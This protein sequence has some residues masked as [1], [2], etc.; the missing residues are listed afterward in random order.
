MDVTIWKRDS[1]K[2]SR[3]YDAITYYSLRR[4]LFGFNHDILLI[5]LEEN[6]L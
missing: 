5:L 2:V 1:L 4:Y 3:D 6:G